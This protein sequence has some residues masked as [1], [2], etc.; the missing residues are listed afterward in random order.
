LPGTEVTITYEDSV[1]MG[2]ELEAYPKQETWEMKNV[3]GVTEEKQSEKSAE[4]SEEQ[5]AKS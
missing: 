2:E 5:R 1:I 3:I 4:E